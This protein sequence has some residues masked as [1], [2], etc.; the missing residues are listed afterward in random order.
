MS[1][2]EDPTNP[3]APQ[4]DA[5]T[6]PPTP[7]TLPARATSGGE[8]GRPRGVAFVIL[9]TIVTLGIYHLYWTYKT[10]EEMKSHTGEGIGGVLGLVIAIVFNPVI[11][12]V[13][14]SEVGKMYRRDGRS[15]PMTGWTGL[16]I[17]LPLI[18]FIVWTVKIQGALNRYWTSKAVTA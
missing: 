13:A 17:L 3:A 15:A 4:P 11:W 10:F 6:Q 12:F 8:L 1:D 14:P 2:T 5:V 16:W 9:I 7:P 18:G